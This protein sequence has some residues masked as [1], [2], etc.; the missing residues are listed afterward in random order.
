MNFS[1]FFKKK[2]FKREPWKFW[3][4]NTQNVISFDCDEPSSWY[5]SQASTYKY[6]LCAKFQ[7]ENSPHCEVWFFLYFQIEIPTQLHRYNIFQKIRKIHV[8]TVENFSSRHRS[9]ENSLRSRF[10]ALLEWLRHCFASKMDILSAFQA[11]TPPIDWYSGMG[12][13]TAPTIWK[14]RQ[15]KK[16]MAQADAEL[17]WTSRQRYL[18]CL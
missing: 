17:V 12:L 1:I 10:L 3:F 18:F 7:L 9:K 14:N 2:W 15:R 4:A 5:F 16:L 11:L 13:C 8:F 6:Y